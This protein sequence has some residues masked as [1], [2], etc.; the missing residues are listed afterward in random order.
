MITII[1]TTNR[2]DSL[3]EK[4]SNYYASI[5]KSK[6]IETKIIKLLDL[7]KDSLFSI[8]YDN[9]DKNS[10][11][12]KIKKI[13][14]D[15]EKIVF[16]IPEYNGSFPGVLKVFIDGLSWPSELKNK[17][18]ALIGISSGPQGCALGLSHFTDIL[19]YVGANILSLKLKFSGI[20]NTDI[21]YIIENKNYIKALNDQI[22]KFLEF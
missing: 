9:N 7:P 6:N 13:I 18:C 19:H 1:S 21:K 20:K 11:F 5:L 10:E 22:D 8:L 12:N 14:K 2:K 16:I 4:L 17:K 3:T 15:S